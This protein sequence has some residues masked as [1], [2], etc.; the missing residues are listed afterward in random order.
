[1]S[2]GNEKTEAKI[3]V[4]PKSF[5]DS[6]YYDYEAF[7]KALKEWSEDDC[8]YWYEQAKFYSLEHDG[9]YKDWIGAVKNWKRSNDFRKRTSGQASRPTSEY[10]PAGGMNE[11]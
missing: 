9:K 2:S 8:Y 4:K 7:R 10:K 5:E 11:W 6:P 1:M 3:K